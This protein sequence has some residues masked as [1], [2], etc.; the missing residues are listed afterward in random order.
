MRKWLV[1]CGFVVCITS[2]ALSQFPEQSYDIYGMDVNTGRIFQ[3][4]HDPATGEYNPSWSQNGKF[5]VHD[6]T[7]PSP[8]EQ[9]LGITDVETG[10]TAMLAGGAGGNNAAWSP[11]GQWIAFDRC[12]GF[13]HGCAEASIYVVPA[14]G[15][16]PLLVVS[17]AITP[18]WSQNSGRIVFARPSDGSLRTVDFS[19]TNERLVISPEPGQWSMNNPTWSPNGQWIAFEW[20]GYILK[21]PVDQLGQAQGDIQ[22]VADDFNF[23]YYPTWSNNSK[24][25]VFGRNAALW[26]VPASGGDYAQLTTGLNWG[27]YDPAYSNNGQYIAFARSLAPPLLPKPGIA[28]QALVPADFELSQNYPNPFN[29]TTTIRYAVPTD[30]NVSLAVYDML[31]QKVAQLVEGPASAGYHD[32]QFDASQLASGI[33]VYKLQAGSFVQTKKMLLVK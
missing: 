15:G 3:I 24:T 21:V 10:E 19:G 30:A 18:R 20:Y 22:L 5:I 32:V 17:D 23:N 16:T 14:G 25:I 13:A 28:Q 31:G 12:P 11:N 26:S 27:D 6:V 1:L 9:Y 7:P 29:P 33:Y 8:A 4:S 2:I